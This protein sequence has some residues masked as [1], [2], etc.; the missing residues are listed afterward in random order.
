MLYY[1]FKFVCDLVRNHERGVFF[2]ILGAKV[3]KALCIRQ[4]TKQLFDGIR[5]ADREKE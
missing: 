4:Y 3:S 5:R 1:T 2:L